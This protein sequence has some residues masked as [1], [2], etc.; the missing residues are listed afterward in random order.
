MR[1]KRLI[2]LTGFTLIVILILG[3]AGTIWLTHARAMGLIHP[4]R[5]RAE[6]TPADVGIETWEEVR[7]ASTDGIELAAWFVPPATDGN[8][9]TIIFLHGF[10]SNRGELLEQAEMLTRRGYGALLPDMRN[11]GDS[12]GTLTTLGFSEVDDVRASVDYL[13]SRPEVNAERIGLVGLSMG[14]ATALRATARIPEI[15]AVVAEAA[16]TSIEDNIADGVQAFTGLPA[17]PFAPLIIWFCQN[18]SG[19]SMQSIRP[20]DD[21]SAIAPRPILFIHGERD[22][23]INV[24]N[25]ERL[26]EAASE[27]KEL[28][29]IADAAHGNYLDHEPEEFERRL[30]AFFEMNVPV[31]ESPQT[32]S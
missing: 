14:A 16:Y 1:R 7:F 5:H 25:S 13:L 6:N 32:E 2:N 3:S 17:F 30:V 29:L 22:G 31:I 26:Y 10:G 8:G 23:L 24:H 27:P 21:L 18:E 20:I 12:G 28:Y 4:L 9:A 15:R 11:H 19:V